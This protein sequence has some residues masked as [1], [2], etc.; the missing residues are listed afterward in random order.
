MQG[1]YRV[2]VLPGDGIGPEVTAQALK[3]LKAVDE[4]LGVTFRLQN[5]LIG[6]CA[7]DATAVPLPAETIAICNNAHAILLGSV[8]GPQWDSKRPEARP[9]AGLLQLRQREIAN[10]SV[11]AR[12][13]LG[14][15]V[16]DHD[17]LVIAREVNIHFDR[18]GA[19]FPCEPDGGEGIFRS[20]AFQAGS[21]FDDLVTVIDQ[22]FAEQKAGR[23]LAVTDPSE[24]TKLYAASTAGRIDPSQPGRSVPA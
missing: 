6:G 21:D 3:T 16:V 8:G 10:Q 1:P 23:Q 5:G 18:V 22:S 15:G 17:H 24:S 20:V 14:V 12:D 9:E 2:A 7:V 4:V 13:P 19:L 11:H